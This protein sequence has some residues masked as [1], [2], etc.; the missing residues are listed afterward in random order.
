MSI[1]NLFVLFVLGVE[2]IYPDRKK[3][4]ISI[5]LY[6]IKA[7]SDII[8]SAF[9]LELIWLLVYSIKGNR[10]LINQK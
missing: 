4:S 7:W 5:R 8:L 9:S 6:N 10:N 3:S 1:L 2:I